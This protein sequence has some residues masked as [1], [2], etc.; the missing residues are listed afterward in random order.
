MTRDYTPPNSIFWPLAFGWEGFL[1]QVF[2]KP[3]VKTLSKYLFDL[4]FNRKMQ[5]L[6]TNTIR[7]T[8]APKGSL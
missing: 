1:N 2:F 5:F 7:G 8:H 3:E 6:E 4:N